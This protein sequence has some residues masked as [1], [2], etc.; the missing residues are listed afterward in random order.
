MNNLPVISVIITVYE[1]DK[2]LKDALNSVLNQTIDNDKYEIIVVG[3]LQNKEILEFLNKE[4]ITFIE[5]WEKPIGPKIVDGVMKAKGNIISL[6]EDDDLFHADKLEIVLETFSQDKSLGFMSHPLHIINEKGD[7]NPLSNIGYKSVYINKGLPDRKEKFFKAWQ[8]G[9][10]ARYTSSTVSILRDILLDNVNFL[11]QVNFSPDSFYIFAS[12]KSK[13]NMYYSEKNLG[14]FRM[15]LTSLSKNIANLENFIQ[16]KRM[17][18]FH[19]C[20]DYLNYNQMLKDT[21]LANFIMGASIFHKIY[22]NIFN[23]DKIDER[24]KL[25]LMD[26]IRWVIGFQDYP[27]KH[28]Y[29]KFYPFISKMPWPIREQFIKKSFE[30]H[31]KGYLSLL[32][33]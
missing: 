15:S 21:D 23:K 31:K 28:W 25:G 3:K 5:N 24:C 26:M 33:A 9:S 27:L 8:Q 32:E 11:R 29:N 10:K 12:Y 17:Y 22:Y 16:H 13:Y 6:L 19:F 4:R 18:S 14:D 30:R 2:F 20:V 7:H 1:R